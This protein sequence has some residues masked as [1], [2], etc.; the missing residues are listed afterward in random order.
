M[1]FDLRLPT[2]GIIGAHERI[3]SFTGADPK[4]SLTPKDEAWIQHSLFKEL[5][6]RRSRGSQGAQPFRIV[7]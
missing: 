1:E 5:S 2:Q 6:S 7:S 4:P 3:T